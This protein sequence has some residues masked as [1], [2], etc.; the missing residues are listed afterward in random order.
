VVISG[1]NA[2]DGSVMIKQGKERGYPLGDRK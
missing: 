2:Y 1:N